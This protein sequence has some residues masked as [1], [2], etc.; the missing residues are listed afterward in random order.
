MQRL[1]ATR[2][3]E[4]YAGDA[5]RESLRG[6]RDIERRRRGEYI[7]LIEARIDRRRQCVGVE[8][9]ELRRVDMIAVQCQL[10]CSR[11][12]LD[13]GLQIGGT[14][15]R[16]AAQSVARLVQHLEKI[17]DT[18]GHRVVV[19]EHSLDVGVI[20]DQLR[21]IGRS[22]RIGLDDWKLRGR[23][24]RYRAW[25]QPDRAGTVNRPPRYDGRI[26]EVARRAGQ[27]DD[28]SHAGVERCRA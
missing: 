19:E 12:V 27:I 2:I 4:N 10:S 1:H 9:I 25:I 18:A 15:E 13:L 11:R 24:F 22:R 23:N 3:A 5:S 6:L 26:V 7:D 20:D 28:R 21:N 14:A 8:N 16:N 17:V